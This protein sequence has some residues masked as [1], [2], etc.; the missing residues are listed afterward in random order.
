MKK[1]MLS[2][3]LLL[4]ALLC[5]SAAAAATDLD[6]NSTIITPSNV[7]KDSAI[8][9]YLNNAAASNVSNSTSTSDNTDSTNN[10]GYAAHFTD[11]EYALMKPT[12]VQTLKDVNHVD[13]PN[14]LV[15]TTD[16]IF[17]PSGRS[18]NNGMNVLSWGE[19][20]LAYMQEQ[21]KTVLIP[22]GYWANAAGDNGL[23]LW[24]R[25]AG[26]DTDEAMS[27]RRTE[28]VSPSS[29]DVSLGVA[30]VFTLDA[31]TIHFA[32]SESAAVWASRPFQYGSTEI[33]KSEYLGNKDGE[34]IPSPTYGM[35]L[36]TAY[37]GK[38]FRVRNLSCS[39]NGLSFEYAGG[40][41][42]DYVMI[43]AYKGDNF[44]RGV[45]GY[46][47]AMRIG[48]GRGEMSVEMT[49]NLKQ[50][51]E[52]YTFKIWMENPS[53][54]NLAQ[55]TEPQTFSFKNGSFVEA[56]TNQ[57][58]EELPK[59]LRMF[60]MKHELNCSWGD[61]RDSRVSNVLAGG[62]VPNGVDN[63]SWIMGKSCGVNASNQIIYFGMESHSGPDGVVISKPLRFWIAGRSGNNLTLYQ[64]STN[65]KQKHVFDKFAV[66]T[67]MT[68]S[69]LP[70]SESR[71]P[72]YVFTPVFTP[73]LS[74]LGNTHQL[75][76]TNPHVAEVDDDGEVTIR[77]YGEF[78]LILFS[79]GKA[80]QTDTIS[81]VNPNPPQYI[82]ASK[83]LDDETQE[84]E[85]QP[86]QPEQPEEAVQDAADG[87]P[88]TGDSSVLPLWAAALAAALAGLAAR[89]RR[90]A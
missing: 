30:P 13:D 4:A 47:A 39:V 44:D 54:V 11:A 64:V 5:L 83:W 68:I 51:M 79:G 19:K 31:S 9:K 21:D 40:M 3:A 66:E 20:D 2:A 27:Y 58:I 22:L 74:G 76:S 67:Q 63:D 41:P 6:D 45:A 1:K 59:N 89:R 73:V 81:V 84:D 87:L 36:K 38:D 32:S 70:E 33:E 90:S 53:T 25:S 34:Q 8:R 24:L 16:R 15:T 62:A 71:K 52:G 75:I 43:Q 61:L 14:S 88:Q 7:W 57:E 72:G 82:P 60:A 80:V 77:N 69:G 28:I 10:S 56:K 18:V 85:A 29:V 12:T 65:E 48:D 35:Y 42:G 37:E 49:E 23:G 46:A 26:E 55:A 78:S 50:N 86:E 17:L